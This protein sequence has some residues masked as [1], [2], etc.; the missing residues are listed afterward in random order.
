M[1]YIAD[2]HIHSPYS[3]AT[4]KSSNLPGLYSWAQVK[5]INLVGT[6]D[7]THPAW[8]S[9]LKEQLEPA[10]PGFFKLRDDKVP[11]ALEG[12]APE[13]IPVRF[14]L[15]AEISSIYKRH[16]KVRKVHNILYVPDF[17]AA[18][19]I[20]I[21]LAGI[22]NIESDGRPILGLDSRDLLEILLTEAPGGFLVPAHIWT[23]WFSLF[24][25]KSGFDALEECYGDL[26]KHI[27]ALE[28]GLSSDPEMN[29]MISA[30]DRYAL[31]SN[32]DCHS[33]GKLGREANIF[34]TDFSYYGMRAALESP[35]S[36]KFAATVEFFPEE[37]K[38]HCD[39]H[40]KC[41]VCMEPRETRKV[42]A[43][44]PVC[45]RPL[46]VGVLHRVM[47][48]AD[49]DEP[50]FPTGSPAVHSLIPLPE[51]LGEM[52]SCGPNTKTVM[53]LYGKLIARFGSEYNLLLNTPIEDINQ[54]S[55]VLG[56]AINRMRKG[57]VIRQPGYDGEFGVI[58]VFE[59]NEL[60]ELSGQIS[61]FS[62]KKPRK[63]RTANKPRPLPK[64]E[65]KQEPD[66][67][68][69]PRQLNPEQQKIVTSTAEKILVSA[70][71]GTGK[72]FTLVTR[73][74]HLLNT[75]PIKA[76]KIV[77]ITFTNR[78]ADEMRTRLAR[79]VGE[80]GTTVQ[81]GT[82]H[83]YCLDWLRKLQ[84]DLQVI[85]EEE[86]ELFLRKLL[87]EM[88]RAE[89]TLFSKQLNQYFDERNRDGATLS[90]PEKMLKRYLSAMQECQAIDLDYV[91]PFFI[92]TLEQ[93]DTFRAEVTSSLE[94]LC[95]DEFQDL[96]QAQFTLVQILGESC[97]IF[98]IGDPNQAIYGFRGSDLHFFYRF[99]E[100]AGVESMQLIRNY[101]S[102]PAII[103]AATA[104]IRRNRDCG[105]TQ[106]IPQSS[107][108]VSIGLHQAPSPQAE[109]E[110]IVRSIEEH[111]GG[112]SSYSIN[113]GRG[114]SEGAGRSFAD[115]AVLYRL[116]QQAQP[117]I[118]ALEKQGIPFQVVGSTPFYMKKDLKNLYHF[119]QT[120]S[121]QATVA[122]YLV[123][124]KG[125]IG[126][127]G[128]TIE[129]LEKELPIRLDDFFTAAQSVKLP[130]A[131]SEIIS[132]IG[133]ARTH[134]FEQVEEVGVAKSLAAI[135]DHL[136]IDEQNPE[137]IRFVELATIFG[138][139][140]AGFRDHLKQNAQATV[141]DERA[142]GV[143][144][145][146]MHGAK[147]LEFPVV[148]LPGLEE[149]IL[150]CSIG[151]SN[152]DVEEERRLFYV[153]MTRAQEQLTLSS[154]ASRTIFNRNA[155]QNISRFIEEIPGYLLEKTAAPKTAKKKSGAKQMKLF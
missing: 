5:G 151:A 125:I 15:T 41:Q 141:Y 58:R 123:L 95:I 136:D 21:K 118:E 150:P 89:R 43:K 26:S 52:L 154:C 137:T 71:P 83:R 6:G 78:A 132:E 69:S 28:T 24:G 7:F 82:F 16:D 148:F 1:K 51:V 97:H 127:G 109:A 70:G 84:P 124:L 85:S 88:D 116:S 117:L 130:R 30:L 80:R 65:K 54:M 42:D 146:T 25:S 99:Q 106:L 77:A 149:E 142:E 2:L 47:E 145:M 115:F 100:M 90:I 92:E 60:D 36:D 104:L 143:A 12:I 23:P 74:E 48:L 111:M 153:A 62:G 139:D 86:R 140:L 27:F 61:M 122:D 121:P 120:T 93:D 108:Q 3:R 10:E 105:E 50:H 134:F 128:A 31:I 32:S 79:D 19:K 147:G 75:T 114:S 129:Q 9:Q 38:Y 135:F 14:T 64:Q 131:S 59:E 81:V 35:L 102:A 119:I 29:R 133:Q 107:Q 45:G 113:S 55:T 22:G 98:A 155:A 34:T 8:F 101:R 4:S 72:T 40:R 53:G 73:I 126:I 57:Q 68:S 39:G 67:S 152:L 63:K 103:D 17:E 76:G 144:L 37:G 49:R 91:I 18:E 66:A 56:E 46:T 20:N 96:N 87:P 11:Q 33:P 138:N 94:Y 13:D 44:C 112:I 110:F